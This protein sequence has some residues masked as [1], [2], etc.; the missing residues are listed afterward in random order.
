MYSQYKSRWTH[1]VLLACAPS[2]EIVFISKSYGGR[3]TD[4]ELTVKSGFVNLV[5]A[6][7][8]IMADKGRY[9]CDTR[10]VFG[11][12]DNPLKSDFIFTILSPKLMY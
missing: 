5:E 3:V 6:G 7:D 10:K 4:S 12:F 2:G 8:T 11:Y 9:T 1:K